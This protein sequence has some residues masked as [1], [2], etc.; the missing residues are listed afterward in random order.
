MS[1][2]LLL[3]LFYYLKKHKLRNLLVILIQN[4]NLLKKQLKFKQFKNGIFYAIMHVSIRKDR[5][6]EKETHQPA[7]KFK[8]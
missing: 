7:N 8:N 6:E 3:C 4:S 2:N 1:L 5:I